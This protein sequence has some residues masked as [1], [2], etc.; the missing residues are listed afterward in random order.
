MRINVSKRELVAIG[1][2]VL[3]YI[4]IGNARSIQPNPIIP[5][6][7]IAV[8][9]VV[10]VIAGVLFGARAGLLVGV[11]GTL[12]NSFI[13]GASDLVEKDL[14]FERLAVIPHG[15]MGLCAGLLRD[16]FPTPIVAGTLFIG[17]ILNIFMF[18]VYGLISFSILTIPLFWYGLGFEVLA[19]TI[20]VVIVV[21]LY[22]LITGWGRHRTI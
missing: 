13:P 15:I 5:G 19:G 4:L 6:A 12:I 2:F 9:M 16:R 17:H 18:G 3:L 8:N 21:G 11:V 10:P 14:I 1:A 20:T 22:R 7:V